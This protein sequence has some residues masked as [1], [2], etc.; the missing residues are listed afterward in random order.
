MKITNITQALQGVHTVDGVKFIKP[1]ES[2]VLEFDGIVADKIKR[3]KLF[4]MSDDMNVDA[5]D[6]MEGKAIVTEPSGAAEDD[7]AARHAE[8]VDQAKS[9]C[10]DV[11]NRWGPNGREKEIE[12]KRSGVT[13]M[14]CK[15]ADIGFAAWA[16]ENGLTV[17]D[18]TV[19]AARTRGSAFVDGYEA[20]F[21]GDRTGGYDQE[22]AWPRT[23][24]STYSGADIPS[25]SIPVA[26][27][28]A[29]YVAAFQELSVPGSLSPV[30][31]GTETVKREK[32][33]SLE[34]EYAT[35][36]TVSDLRDLAR[37]I[38]TEIEALLLPFIYQSGA[39]VMVV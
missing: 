2:R 28:T 31:I 10:V 14:W 22:R 24:A 4:V 19:A 36:T 25:S 11:E 3:S 38:M 7:E 17:P 21:P 6:I 1:G 16:I 13:D 20:K 18:G 23:G 39:A 32:V 12:K 35:A 33:G 30:I 26:I 37:P 29:S 27:V 5:V 34:V 8:L 15:G 9:L